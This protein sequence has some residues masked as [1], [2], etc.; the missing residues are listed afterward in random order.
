MNSPAATQTILAAKGNLKRQSIFIQ[1]NYTAHDQH[2]KYNLR[3]LSKK[4]ME[5]S[6]STKTKLGE[7]CIYIDD[8]KIP[9][10]MIIL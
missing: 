10:Q 7:F 2:I 9:G 1:K 8:K 6:S 4:I 5:D 3:K